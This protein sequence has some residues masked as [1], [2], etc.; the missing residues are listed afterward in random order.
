M[1]ELK[2]HDGPDAAMAAAA[3]GV[4]IGL[5]ATTVIGCSFV[6]R[7]ECDGDAAPEDDRGK[8]RSRSTWVERREGKAAWRSSMLS[9]AHATA[10]CRSP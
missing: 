1:E 6:S 4:A 5:V 3:A 8:G 9:Q 2:S 10:A 7:N